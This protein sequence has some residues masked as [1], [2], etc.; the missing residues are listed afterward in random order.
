MTS[1]FAKLREG[2]NLS[3]TRLLHLARPLLTY[4]RLNKR[5]IINYEAVADRASA[6]P[7]R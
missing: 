6:L 2:A 3:A 1:E 5:A 7:W 4:F